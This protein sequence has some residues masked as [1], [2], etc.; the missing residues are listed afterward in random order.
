MQNTSTPRRLRASLFAVILV[1]SMSLSLAACSVPTPVP[2]VAPTKAVSQEAKTH[3][4]AAKAALKDKKFDAALTEAQAA[5]AADPQSSEAQYLL[6]N[7]YNQIGG[8]ETDD[9]KRRDD[10]ARA[11]DAYLAAIKLDPKND[12]AYT[13]LATVYYQNGQFDEAQT[14]VEAALKLKPDDSVSHYVLGTIHLQ[15]DPKKYPDALD[16]AEQEFL[17]ALKSDSKLGAAYVGLANVYL[18]KGDYQK[19]LE[20]RRRVWT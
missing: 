15:R 5:V 1:A 2:T 8:A 6:G 4:D 3:I 17:A 11:V 20:T 7:A 12:A 9:T 16:K 19:A 10:L 14:Q 13:N 18:F